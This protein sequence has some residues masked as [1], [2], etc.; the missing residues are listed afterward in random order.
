MAEQFGVLLRRRSRHAVPRSPL[1]V[2]AAPLVWFVWTSKAPVDRRTVLVSP[3]SSP[4]L[5]SLKWESA[6]RF[7]DRRGE[8]EVA[9]NDAFCL[10]CPWTPLQS[11]TAAASR[12]IPCLAESRVSCA[13]QE[14]QRGGLACCATGTGAVTRGCWTSFSGGVASELDTWPELTGLF[15]AGVIH[16]QAASRSSETGCRRARGRGDGR[17]LSPR[18]A[19]HRHRSDDVARASRCRGPPKRRTTRRSPSGPFLL[20]RSPK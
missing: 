3:S 15:G 6:L 1:P 17:M 10:P 12:H 5:P 9:S 4:F 2:S 20:A 7:F 16:H 13:G 11:M 8:R 19:R 18:T 14:H